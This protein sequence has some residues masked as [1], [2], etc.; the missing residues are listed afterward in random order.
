M[1]DLSC[2]PAILAELQHRSDLSEDE[3]GWLRIMLKTIDR[4]NDSRRL[5]ENRIDDFMTLEGMIDNWQLRRL[6]PR[7]LV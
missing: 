2:L 5:S 6:H 1:N 3:V 7:R 4:T